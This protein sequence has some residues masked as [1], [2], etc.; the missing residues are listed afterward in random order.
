MGLGARRKEERRTPKA[1]RM[2][3]GDEQFV[4]FE[5]GSHCGGS[6]R[7]EAVGNER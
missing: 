6:L 3:S 5:V 1:T 4:A 2:W 7:G